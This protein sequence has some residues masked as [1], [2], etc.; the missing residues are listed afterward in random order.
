MADPRSGDSTQFRRILTRNLILPLAMGLG[1]IVVFVG[2]LWH[3]M[4]LLNWVDHSHRVVAK[5][6]EL[7]TL[8]A[9][10]ES[11]LRGFLLS[12]QDSF[13]A[14]Y[15]LGQAK[16]LAE[17]AGAQDLVS[18]NPAQV[19]RLRRISALAQRWTV[20]AETT[21][22]MRRRNE[23][24][25]EL[26]RTQQG[27][28]LIDEM[29]REL[30]SFG[31]TELRLLRDRNED[32][33]VGTW[34]S[35]GG[36]ISLLIIVS[37]LIA[38]AGRRDIKALSD[39]YGRALS[40]LEATARE[41]EA[42]AWL[43]G[44]QAELSAQL[45]GERALAGIAGRTLGFLAERI[46]AVVSAAFLRGDDGRL[47]CVAAHGFAPGAADARDPDAGLLAQVWRDG[48]LVR[49]P[50]L[51]DD[52]LK[53]STSLGDTRPQD[54]VLVPAVHEGQVNAVLELG[55][56][57]PPDDRALGLLALVQEMLGALVEAAHARQR[58]QASVE[59]TRQLNEELQVQQEELRTANEELSE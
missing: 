19:E 23:P 45:M 50:G 4:M 32:A 3:L 34:M 16:F 55:F 30:R 9:D 22:A 41:S 11:G 18:D 29:R 39:E 28:Q 40:G 56:T 7:A 57:Q 38:W 10:Q 25:E 35:V 54:L 49:L 24:V 17:L 15:S 27:K 2:L 52:F 12:G 36:Y 58:L 21:I 14:P 8:S 59:E 47:H 1:S 46:D 33:Q 26:I 6:H 42:R 31:E 5:G 20:F 44:T 37:G 51:A 43:R 53:V 13:L 48:K